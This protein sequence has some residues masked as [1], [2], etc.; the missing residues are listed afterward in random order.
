MCMISRGIEKFGS[1]TSTIA[2]L[3]RFATDVTVRASFLKTI[4]SHA[5]C[6]AIILA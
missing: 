6:R 4:P 3:G 2:V 1:Y 5:S